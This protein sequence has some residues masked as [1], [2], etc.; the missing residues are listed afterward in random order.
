MSSKKLS[1]RFILVN[2]ILPLNLILGLMVIFSQSLLM[3]RDKT[4]DELQSRIFLHK[5]LL[6]LLDHY[7]SVSHPDWLVFAALDSGEIL[8]VSDKMKLKKTEWKK[9]VPDFSPEMIIADVILARIIKNIPDSIT[10]VPFLYKGQ[11]GIAVYMHDLLPLY[12]QVIQ[13]PVYRLL[14]FFM[15]M[16]LFFLGL[17]QMNSHYKSVRRLIRASDRISN[18]DLDTEIKPG[19]QGEMATVFR[20]F[21]QM[22]KAL[23][24]NREKEARFVMSVTHDLKTPLSAMRMYL[25][26]MKDGYI[27]ISDE[28]GEAVNKILLKSAMLE[29]RI[30][31]LLDYSKLQTS[32]HELNRETIRISSWI[33]EQNL[34]FK[35]ESLLNNRKY[36]GEIKVDE[37]L[38][39]SGNIKLLNRAL[40]NLI[41]NACRYTKENDII[42]F[43][44][45]SK[46]NRL[47]LSFENSGPPI[48]YEER[49]KI[50]ELFYRADKGRNSR[51]MGIGLASVQSVIE[52]HGGTIVCGESSL[53]GAAF[54]I[55]I[56]LR[57]ME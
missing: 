12:L 19:K 23:K 45:V 10:I 2:L 48:P 46:N 35:E 32:I 31:E 57:L 55:R 5:P 20:S 8:H 29:D 21:E 15:T 37:S 44:A 9:D 39:I 14:I 4:E 7:D 25:E 38:K 49:E 17:L 26:A 42:Q 33:E 24:S 34:L 1:R 27:K 30:A 6:N 52:N 18:H 36:T 43:R 16:M 22:R 28:A 51:G 3:E 11:S 54:E 40:Q 13:K 56:P 53:G 41:D 50:F 47:L